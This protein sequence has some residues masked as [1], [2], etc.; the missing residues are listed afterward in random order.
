MRILVVSDSHSGTSFMFRCADAVKPDGIVHLG[1]Y[2]DDG[3]LLRDGYPNARVWLI[4][5][6]CDYYR[7]PMSAKSILT[8]IIGGVRFYLTHGHRHNVKMGLDSLLA[9]ARTEQAGV[10]LFGHT[11]QA[12]CQQ[13]PDGLW[14]L[15]P[16][17]CGYGYTAGLVEV[18]DGKVL[19]CR[20]LRESDLEEFA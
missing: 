1:D 16:G 11:H 12:L 4:A 18:A 19:T 14:V 2:Y 6:N 17:S 9:A 5:G 7:A 3:E 15:N 20:V 8:P 13:E 10:V